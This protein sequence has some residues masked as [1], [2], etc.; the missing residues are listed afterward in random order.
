M[1]G[2]EGNNQ[3]SLRM[4]NI[5]TTLNRFHGNNATDCD[6]T[7]NSTDHETITGQ[8]TIPSSESYGDGI[9]R[10]RDNILRVGFI[11]INGVPGYN[12]HCK[13]QKIYEAV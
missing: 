13:N 6:T 5:S 4:E 8:D 2:Y 7:G 12:E 3:S 1:A 10:K 9:R 11:N